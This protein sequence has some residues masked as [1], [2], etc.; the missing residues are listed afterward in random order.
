MTTFNQ[1]Y[2]YIALVGSLTKSCNDFFLSVSR[3]TINI[4]KTYRDASDSSGTT[5]T[6]V[7]RTGQPV[8][9]FSRVLWA[10]NVID[11][12]KERKET[13]EDDGSDG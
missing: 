9:R 7:I 4:T 12:R 10:G 5:F 6:Y 8:D 11:A 13:I 2:K 1:I 3:F